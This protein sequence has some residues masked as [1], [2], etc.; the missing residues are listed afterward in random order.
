MSEVIEGVLVVT[1]TRS[2][3]VSFL[4]LHGAGKHS[5][6]FAV[7]SNFLRCESYGVVSLCSCVYESFEI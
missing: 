2:E 5:N 7:C 4:A 1:D 6:I 3:S